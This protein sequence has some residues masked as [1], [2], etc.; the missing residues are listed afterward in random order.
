MKKCY[1]IRNVSISDNLLQ[2][3]K[4]T[5]KPVKNQNLPVNFGKIN[6]A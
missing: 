5:G 2:T 3:F 1:F 6:E 4:F